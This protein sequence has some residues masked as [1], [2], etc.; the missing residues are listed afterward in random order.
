MKLYIIKIL[1]I[2]FLFLVINDT[3]SQKNNSN[4]HI[5]ST[6]MKIDSLRI[7][8]KKW[9]FKP[10]SFVRISIWGKDTLWPNPR[11]AT[12]SSLIIPGGGQFYNKSYWK[13]PLVYATLGTCTYFIIQNHIQYKRYQLAYTIRNDKDSTTF[14]EFKDRFANPQQIRVYRDFYKRNRDFLIILGVIGYSLNIIEAYVDA[15]LKNFDVSDDLSLKISPPLPNVYLSGIS[16]I[17]VGV[18]LGLTLSF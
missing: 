12:L 4:N 1:I 18:K 6:T 10:L 16:E 3:Y 2:I 17:K 14:D 15:H 11:K 8:S 9:K 5:D 13:I 7:N